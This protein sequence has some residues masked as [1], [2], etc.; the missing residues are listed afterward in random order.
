M[1]TQIFWALAGVA[2]IP[3]LITILFPQNRS[4]FEKDSTKG[5]GLGVYLMLVIMLLRESFEHAGV[6]TGGMWFIAGLFISLLIGITFKEFHHHHTK[7]EAVH[8]HT[9]SSTWRI[10]ISDFFHN[11]V[12]G[13]AIIA[14][15]FV[16]PTV[17]VTSF[18]GILGHQ[19]IQQA[20]QQILLVESGIKTTKAIMISFLIS[21]SIFLGYIFQNFEPLEV[22]FMSVSAGIVAWKVIA[23]MS[24]AKWSKKMVFGFAIGAFILA[25]ILVLVPHEH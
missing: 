1:Q 5:F 12:D 16:T 14:G 11:I 20:G 13:I 18:L 10:L 23:D 17:G 24:G 15:F 22:I 2:I 7:E 4:F 21:L 25:L 19:T 3:I 9:K 6:L 8:S